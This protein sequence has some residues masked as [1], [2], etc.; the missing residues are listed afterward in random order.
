MPRW[1]L[2]FSISCGRWDYIFSF[3]KKFR[4]HA[5]FALPQR[6]DVTMEQPFLRSYVELLIHTCHQRGIHAM[7]G[8]VA[9]IPDVGK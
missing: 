8:M 6:G 1:D 7:G 5:G 3:V 4:N 9:Q 2:R